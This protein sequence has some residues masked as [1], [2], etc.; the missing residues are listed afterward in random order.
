[1]LPSSVILAVI[2][3][4]LSFSV[5]KKYALA[6]RYEIDASQVSSTMSTEGGTTTQ[7]AQHPQHGRTHGSHP[8]D[9]TNLTPLPI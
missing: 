2:S 4:M 1:M 5:A 9:I 7:T 6:N 3:Y 8:T